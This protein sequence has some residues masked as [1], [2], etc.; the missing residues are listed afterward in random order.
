MVSTEALSFPCK[1]K[2]TERLFKVEKSKVKSRLKISILVSMYMYV[3]GRPGTLV[4]MYG[5]CKSKARESI[6][7]IGLWPLRQCGSKLKRTRYT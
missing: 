2:L 1:P 3:K 4:S 7:L 6:F 5:V